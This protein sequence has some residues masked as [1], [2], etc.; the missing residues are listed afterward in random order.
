MAQTAQLR[1]QQAFDLVGAFQR[2]GGVGGYLQD[3][4]E[5]LLQIRM[6]AQL[7]DQLHFLWVQLW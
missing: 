6:L 2:T 3:N 7:F 5:A 1:D 4:L